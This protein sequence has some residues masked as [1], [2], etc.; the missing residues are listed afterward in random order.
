MKKF[1]KV[2]GRHLVSFFVLSAIIAVPLAVGAVINPIDNLNRVNQTAGFTEAG[3]DSL[4][5]MIGLIISLLLGI[6]GVILV[7]LIIY[8]GFLWMFSQG[9]PG[10]V[11]K[12]KDIIF[13]A[14]IGLVI[15]FAAYAIAT[16]VLINLVEI[17]S[18]G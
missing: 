11:K 17:A 2:S 5:N 4:Y 8:A 6:L 14:I 7:I 1:F 9:D 12:A 3:P 15:I 13:Q 16:F 10:K 18:K